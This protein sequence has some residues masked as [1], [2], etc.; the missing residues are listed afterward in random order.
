MSFE[1]ES[2]SS[3]DAQDLERPD[4]G[5]FLIGVVI[6]A[7]VVSIFLASKALEWNFQPALR[8][9]IL[10]F[11]A[12]LFTFAVNMGLRAIFHLF[13]TWRRS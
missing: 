8:Y 6:A 5:P 4:A 1:N 9:S 3:Y 2:Q 10:I 12:A 11:T 7:I 13:S